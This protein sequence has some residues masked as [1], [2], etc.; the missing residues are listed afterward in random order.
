MESTSQ[1]GFTDHHWEQMVHKAVAYQQDFYELL[2]SWTTCKKDDIKFI[3]QNIGYAIFGSPLFEKTSDSKDILNF[4]INNITDDT[5][6]N[7]VIHYS[8]NAERLI[9]MIF[10]KIWKHGRRLKDDVIN[11]GIVYNILFRNKINKPSKMNNEE[12]IIAVPVFK[13]QHYNDDLQ[14]KSN[15]NNE[16]IYTVWYIDIKGRLYKSWENYISKN[17]L[18]KC[19]MVFPKN[20]YYQPNPEYKIISDDSIVWIIIQDS[21]MCSTQASILSK[22]NT[23]INI[24]GS[25]ATL[26]LGIAT[27]F[28]PGSPLIALAGM[29]AMGVTGIWTIGKSS[30]ELY[31]RAVH[32]ESISPFNRNALSAWLGIAGSTVGIVLSGTTVLLKKAA[33]AGLQVNRMATVAHDAMVIT[34]ISINLIGVG[35]KSFQ[36]LEKFKEQKR[37]DIEDIIYIGTHLLF[38]THSVVNI[39]FAKQIIELTQGNILNKIETELRKDNL[40]QHYEFTK[41]KT[42]MGVNNDKIIEKDAAIIRWFKTITI[43]DMMS[44][45]NLLTIS[46]CLL[47]VERGKIKLNGITLL[48]PILFV[49]MIGKN[50]LK[51]INDCEDQL[52]TYTD[53]QTYTLTKLLEKLLSDLYTSRNYSSN[54]QPCIVPQFRSLI[55]ELKKIDKSENILPFIFNIAVTILRSKNQLE[56]LV[57]GCRFV[58][59]YI[60]IN[61]KETGYQFSTENNSADNNKIMEHL[62]ITIFDAVDLMIQDFFNALQQYIHMMRRTH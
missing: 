52:N 48:D 28:T 6:I 62:F 53:Q 44:N 21:S 7:E 19:T 13:I 27:I 2:P 43:N 9:N 57:E 46:N 36:I 33:T 50:L 5:E 10:D 26:G 39:K 59:D 22:V 51:K 32:E 38:F 61:L 11:Y 58:W 34:S 31:D 1:V 30:T 15:T 12:E 14:T 24:A 55:E 49:A 29:A 16:N 41:K 40:C 3:K 18:P 4:D 45:N 8:P 25:A 42:D 56:Y 23:T 20:G 47:S 35:Y 60:K 17:N 37:V 54:E